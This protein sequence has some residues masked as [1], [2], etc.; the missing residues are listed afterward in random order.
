MLV[1]LW[2]PITVA[3]D[4][5]IDYYWLYGRASGQPPPDWD[6]LTYF[7]HWT[8]MFV[9]VAGLAAFINVLRA[10]RRL[11]AT[12]AT[13]ASIAVP[14]FGAP[15]A[16]GYSSYRWDFWSVAHLLLMQTAAT[17]GLFITVYFWLGITL[18]TKTKLSAGIVNYF[19]HGGNCV[20]LLLEVLLTRI[21]FVSYHFQIML[22]FATLYC[23]FLWLYGELAGTWRYSLDWHHPEA[24]GAY[25]LLAVLAVI[26]F[27]IWLLIAKFRECALVRPLKRRRNR[28]SAATP[29]TPDLEMA[30]YVRG[31]HAGY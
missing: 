4:I 29:S 13:Q 20:L 2:L 24:V 31:Q 8:L 30:A 19:E 1:I 12:P 15:A 7:T 3:V 28:I 27:F 5:G 26:I 14:G 18:V 22:W 16:T 6:W 23:I 17:A 25:A 10:R 9:S 11:R 21:P